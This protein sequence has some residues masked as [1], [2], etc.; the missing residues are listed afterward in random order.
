MSGANDGG[1]FDAMVKAMNEVT[2]IAKKTSS[3]VNYKF[4]S[5]EDVMNAL[6]GPLANNGLFLSV[7]VLDDWAVAPIPGS[8]DNKGNPR[9][10]YQATF[11]VCLDVYHDSGQMVTLGPGLAQS[12]D[13]GD[14]AVYQ[15]QQNAI[16]YLLLTAFAIPTEEQD[17]DARSPDDSM[18]APAH[19]WKRWV[20][21]ESAVFKNWS[22]DERKAAARAA[23]ER[24]LGPT[25]EIA[26]SGEAMIV[27]N[28]MRARYDSGEAQ[29]TLD[30]EA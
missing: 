1:V 13:Y 18:P 11:R 16:K 28:E 24:V 26:N 20:W 9:T 15:A 4:R 30:V 7:R 8:L 19:D 3:G 14:K 17:M 10:Q 21:E 12:H 22:E 29:G 6:H 2:A 25:D 27:L 23:M 5:V